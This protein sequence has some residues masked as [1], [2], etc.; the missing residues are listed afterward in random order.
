MISGNK[1]VVDSNCSQQ[2]AVRV[3]S[4]RA[5][6]LLTHCRTVYGEI[7]LLHHHTTNHQRIRRDENKPDDADYSENMEIMF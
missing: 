6:R 7:R 2:V 1:A 3:H 4:L 5:I